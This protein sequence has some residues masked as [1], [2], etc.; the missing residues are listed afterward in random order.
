MEMPGRE[1]PT[2]IQQARP[3]FDFEYSIIDTPLFDIGNI[4]W[5]FSGQKTD[6]AEKRDL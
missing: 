3:F 6:E 1:M 2:S 5:W 4:A